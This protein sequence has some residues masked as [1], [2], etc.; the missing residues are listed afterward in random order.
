MFRFP[1]A[2][3]A[4]SHKFTFKSL[5]STL[6]CSLLN[7][8]IDRILP[9][10]PPVPVLLIHGEQDSVAPLA[11]VSNL[12]ERYPSMRLLAING[13]GHHVFLTHTRTCLEHLTRF[14]DEQ[15]S[16]ETPL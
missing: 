11:H 10:V 5:T 12:P 8:Q 1:W 6:E 14:L 3:I 4:D 13:T 9:A 2:V 7:Y 15:Q 16:P